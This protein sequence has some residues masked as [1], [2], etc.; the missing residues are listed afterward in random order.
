[1]SG[2]KAHLKPLE[3]RKQLLLAESELNRVRLLEEWSGLNDEVHRL[4]RQVRSVG[5]L[6][7]LTTAAIAAVSAWRLSSSGPENGKGKSS[8]IATL[9]NG[10]RMGASLWVAL[11]SCFR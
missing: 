6:A 3:A 11:K 4:T 9:L 10:V 5:A 7:S 2:K 8:W 1:M